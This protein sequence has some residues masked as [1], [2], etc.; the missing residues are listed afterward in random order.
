MTYP[1][2]CETTLVLSNS[3][4]VLVEQLLV[5]SSVLM[6]LVTSPEPFRRAPADWDGKGT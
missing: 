6:Q 2:I 1:Y 4:I 3:P 5:N